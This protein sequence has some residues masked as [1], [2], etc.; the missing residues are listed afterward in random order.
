MSKYKIIEVLACNSNDEFVRRYWY[1]S[2]EKKIYEVWKFKKSRFLFWI[3]EHCEFVDYYQ[4]LDFAKDAILT[5]KGEHP[6]QIK[7]KE[8]QKQQPKVVHEE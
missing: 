6:E 5:L 3:S 1:N 8:L 7:R 4:N 2:P